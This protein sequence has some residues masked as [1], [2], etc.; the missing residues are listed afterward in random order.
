MQAVQEVEIPGFELTEIEKLRM[1][2]TE[3][4]KEISNLRKGIYARYDAQMNEINRLSAAL[5]KIK[6]T[7]NESQDN[8]KIV[9]V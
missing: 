7:R 2:T 8:T 1:L 5:E 3:M 4:K 9:Y 6:E